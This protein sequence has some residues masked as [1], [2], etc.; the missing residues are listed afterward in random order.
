MAPTTIEVRTN[1]LNIRNIKDFFHLTTGEEIIGVFA[2]ISGSIINHL[3]SLV[4]EP[5]A[6]IPQKRYFKQV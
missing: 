3:E 5:L 6:I 4:F 1:R 2:L